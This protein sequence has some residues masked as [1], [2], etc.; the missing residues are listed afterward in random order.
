MKGS[1]LHA[2]TAKNLANQSLLSNCIT[3]ESHNSVDKVEER[4]KTLFRES[5]SVRPARSLLTILSYFD[6]IRVARKRP[7]LW[8]YRLQEFLL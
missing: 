4:E 5:K 7:H 3:D 2:R 1:Q 8:K 6:W